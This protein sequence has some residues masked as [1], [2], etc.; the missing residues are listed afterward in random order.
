MSASYFEFQFKN[1]KEKGD[2]FYYHRN[3]HY[4]TDVVVSNVMNKT[5]I[6]LTNPDLIIEATNASNFMKMEK[7]VGIYE[8]FYHWLKKGLVCM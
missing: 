7:V 1:V 5:D 4:S 3:E 6:V 2:P 8:V